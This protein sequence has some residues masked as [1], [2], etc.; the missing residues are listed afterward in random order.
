MEAELQRRL[1]DARARAD[2]AAADSPPS[3]QPSVIPTPSHQQ[4]ADEDAGG[5]MQPKAAWQ[6]ELA[7]RRQRKAAAQ[8]AAAVAPVVL[9]PQP[10]VVTQL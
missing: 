8:T 2:S 5:R 7:A 10:I 4:A 9:T 3:V 1:A 6:Q